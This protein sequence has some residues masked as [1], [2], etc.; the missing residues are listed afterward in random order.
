MDGITFIV[1][2]TNQMES[3]VPKSIEYTNIPHECNKCVIS[4]ILIKVKSVF[5]INMTVNTFLE[6]I[7]LFGQ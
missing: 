3:Q 6:Y 1:N 2:I 4:N 7:S 5:W